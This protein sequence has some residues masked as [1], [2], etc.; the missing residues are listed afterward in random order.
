MVGS[1]TR[2]MTLAGALILVSTA[3]TAMPIVNLDTNNFVLGIDNL[4]VSGMGVFNV[5]FRWA[6]PSTVFPGLD[7]D[8][9]TS[10]DAGTATLAITNLLNTLLPKPVRVIDGVETRPF[11]QVPYSSLPGGKVQTVLAGNTWGIISSTWEHDPGAKPA[12]NM[13]ADFAKVPEP[14]T[15]T[16]IGFGLAGMGFSRRKTS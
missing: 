2:L 14:T 7:F 9:T 11:F 16:L 8:F 4:E 5:D 1:A 12:A 15:L 10:S 13:W 3:A 6:P